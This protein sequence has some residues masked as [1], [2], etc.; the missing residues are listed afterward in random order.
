[1]TASCRALHPELAARLARS[2]FGAPR[3]SESGLLRISLPLLL[4]PLQ[5]VLE[6]F[7]IGTQHELYLGA[8]LLQSF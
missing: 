2:S 6:L 1:V 5:L 8:C 3:A 7:P 4:E